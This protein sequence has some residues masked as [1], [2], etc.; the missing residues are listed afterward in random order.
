MDFRVISFYLLKEKVQGGKLFKYMVKNIFQ[1][2]L[3]L[4][5]FWKFLKKCCSVKIM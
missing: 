1:N 4:T 3:E 2:E 5:S